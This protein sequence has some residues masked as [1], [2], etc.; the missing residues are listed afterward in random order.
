[1]KKY[2]LEIKEISKIL[3]KESYSCGE[4]GECNRSYRKVSAIL[5][6]IKEKEKQI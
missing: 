5:K 4:C 1:M 3:N 2:H 6:N